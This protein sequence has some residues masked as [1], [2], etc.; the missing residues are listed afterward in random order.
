MEIDESDH[1]NLVIRY[2]GYKDIEVPVGG[3]SDLQISLAP[4]GGKT[5]D[6]VVVVGYGVVKKRDLTGAV[7]TLKSAELQKVPTRVLWSRYRGKVPGMDITRSSGKAGAPINVTVRGNRSLK[8]GNGPLYIVDGIQYSNIED[9]NPAD[10]QSMEVL[11]DASSTAIY[12]SRGANGVIIVTTKRGAEGKAR[13][14]F[15]TYAGASTVAG[16]PKVY[17]GNGYANLRRK[18]TAPSAPGMGRLMTAKFSTRRN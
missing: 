15:N 10:I 16:Y 13:V 5:L 7:T 9:I 14:F 2:M 4:T 11:K 18:L 8:A 6:D 1:C 3:Q 12:G 17:D